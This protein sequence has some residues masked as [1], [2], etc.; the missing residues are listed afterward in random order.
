M[1]DKDEI[2]RKVSEVPFWGHSIPL[3]YGIVTPGKVMNNIDSIGHL[4]LPENL[5]GKS[6][7]DIGTL[8]GYYAF[9]CEKRGASVLAID[10]LKR[11]ERPDEKQ[12]QH[13]GNKGFE[14]VRDILN[15]NVQFINMDVYDI[16]PGTIG[17]FDIVL[18]LGVLYHLKHP[19][20]ALEKIFEV[21]NEFV[22][23]E[24][25]FV[26][27]LNPLPVLYYAEGDSF[28]ADPTNWFIP[29]ESALQGM[30]RDIGF[31]KIQCLYKSKL[32]LLSTA[33][34]L[35]NLSLCSFGRIALRAN[36]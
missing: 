4:N 13:C 31:K 17:K 14:T 12:Y 6:V 9:E 33:K 18:F 32:S 22:I 1:L 26:R 30:L 7:L 19:F 34:S 16:S 20:L 2:L 28:N 29:T 8:D 21:T 15:S 27:T 3:P 23:I 24:S 25:A 10:N 5:E 11:M 36:K 35:L